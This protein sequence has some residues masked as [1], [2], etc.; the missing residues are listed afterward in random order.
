MSPEKVLLLTALEEDSPKYY[1]V[2]RLMQVLANL[3]QRFN[4]PK[5]AHRH[6][7]GCL[8][9]VE[10]H[11]VPSK[12]ST[13]QMYDFCHFFINDSAG[14]Y[15]CFQFRGHHV[16]IHRNGAYGIYRSAVGIKQGS[17]FD[18]SFYRENSVCL[19]QVKNS[20]DESLWQNEYNRTPS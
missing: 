13:M 8:R 2:E 9:I 14:I 17:N 18:W 16:L 7:I 5:G 20:K 3:D 6:I 4:C 1:R 12:R 15:Y 10:E 19:V 11:F